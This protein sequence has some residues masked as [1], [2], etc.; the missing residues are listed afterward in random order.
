[1]IAPIHLKAIDFV[2]A[3]LIPN[4]APTGTL[5]PFIVLV[6]LIAAFGV[7]PLLLSSLVGIF[8]ISGIL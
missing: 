2:P 4:I 1:M 8:G 5:A 7:H 3:L 6:P